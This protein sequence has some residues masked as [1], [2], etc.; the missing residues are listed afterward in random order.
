MITG[1]IVALVT[2]MVEVETGDSPVDWAALFRLIDWHI[3]S[4]TSAIVSVGTTGESAT[5]SFDDHIEVIR[6]TVAHAKGRIPIIAGTGA[7]ATQE[8]L[9]LTQA[10]K[11]CGVE[12]CL[13]VTPYYNKPTQEGLYQHYKRIAEQVDIP[14]I[15]YNV[16]GRTACDLRPETIARLAKLDNIVGVKEATGELNRIK[17]IKD[18]NPGFA[19]YSGDDA[20]STEAMLLGAVG[21]ISVTANVAP[22]QLAK[23]CQLAM[24]GQTEEARAANQPLISLHEQLFVE[25]SPTPVKWALVQ[26]GKIGPAIRLPLLPMSRQYWDTVRQALSEA[27][28]I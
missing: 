12:A 20:S 3:E 9:E 11:A 6:R 4:G 27:G 13:L 21:S 28:V 19:I 25:P 17:I 14:Q 22:E 26:M 18:A 2:P 1:S 16:P 7:N 10:A 24:A 5:L 23:M 8:A 15:L